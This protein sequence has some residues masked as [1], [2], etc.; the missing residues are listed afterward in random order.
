MSDHDGLAVDILP[1]EKDSDGGV[2]QI[3]T[4]H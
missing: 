1:K 4:G 2:A 3:Q